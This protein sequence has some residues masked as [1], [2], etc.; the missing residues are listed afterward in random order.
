M[1][2]NIEKKTCFFRDVIQ[3]TL[4][5]VHIN[6]RCDILST[7]EFVYAVDH[8]TKL[9]SQ[10]DSGP[11]SVSTLQEIQNSLACVIKVVGTESFH[12]FLDVCLGKPVVVP[13][14]SKYDLITKVFH[15]TGYK[16]LD[17]LA[18]SA[19][20]AKKERKRT[21]PTGTGNTG[22]TGG[23]ETTDTPTCG[24]LFSTLECG[25]LSQISPCFFMQ[26]YGMKLHLEQGGKEII[27]LGFVDEEFSPHPYST[28][29]KEQG[30]KIGSPSEDVP[31]YQDYAK[32]LHLKDW[33][34]SSPHQLEYNYYTYITSVTNLYKRDLSTLIQ[35]FVL[36]DL[37]T[38]REM[39]VK[40]L[41]WPRTY[42]LA[43]LLY[44][45]LAN[46]NGSFDQVWMY[47][48]LPWELKK[49]VKEAK[50]V[51]EESVSFDIHQVPMEQQIALLRVEKSV[52]EK[53]MSKLKESKSRE[54]GG[55]ARQY[56]EGLLTIPFGVLR[57]EP[58]LCKKDELLQLLQPQP[59]PIVSAGKIYSRK[60]LEAMS[61][62]ELKDLGATSG[63]R[64]RQKKDAIIETLLTSPTYRAMKV[65]EEISQ[66]M[67]SF[68][69]TMDKAVYGHDPAKKQLEK[70]L[71][72]WVNGK[73]DGYCFGFEG[74]PGVGKTSLAKEGL[75][76][77]LV[78]EQGRPR[79]FAML[80]LGGDSNG[81]TL[82]GH[83]YTYTGSTW[84]AIVQ[85]LMDKKCMNP[86]I[87]IDEVDKISKTE[88][89]RE[90]IGILTHLLDS[91]QN[92]SFQDKYFAGIPLDLSKALFILSYNDPSVL[93]RVLLDRVHRIRFHPLSKKE[94]KVIVHRYLIP[95]ICDKMGFTDTTVDLQE[96]A[97]DA[98]IDIYTSE[99]GV[100]KCKELLF[101]IYGAINVTLLKYPRFLLPVVV[102]KENL[103]TVY[104]KDHPMYRPTYV[105]PLQRAGVCVGLWA[106]SEG[107]GGILP[108]QASWRSGGGDSSSSTSPSL[109]LTGTQGDTMK[110]SMHVALTLALTTTTPPPTTTPLG[111]NTIHIHC[112]DTSTPKD[113]P[114]AGAAITCAIRSL[115]TG[116]VIR[117]TLA[118]TGE[119]CLHGQVTEIGGLEQKF[120]GGIQAGIKEFLFPEE[121]RLDYERFL[122]SYPEYAADCGITFT[123]VQTIEEVFQ[124]VFLD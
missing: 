28:W 124:H 116:K 12:D 50:R 35:E 51:A 23:T 71:G 75:A 5:Y 112:P 63:G 70:I 74:P 18:A 93:D 109:F 100:R 115:M 21:K 102:T 105:N 14:E 22:N 117:P 66:I 82:H 29:L 16:V 107:K 31:R 9:S 83:N 86:I 119:V 2:D 17:T 94:K 65:R 110:E 92:D 30:S 7:N 3:K 88:H 56:L 123:S 39:L 68:R 76:G 38:K 95:E 72:Q 121:N 19:A 27:V 26:V 101:D 11:H 98:L 10:V 4:R 1:M 57:R 45:L 42:L 44:D 20:A 43:N 103:A 91:T 97:L 15:P 25:D 53:A 60:E 78:D 113:G 33:L 108:I 61:Y 37:Y 67:H 122:S 47:D 90:L 55:K 8:L 52:K 69:G 85:I 62:G 64:K 81:S 54:E 41:C 104:L 114:S 49:N 32:G 6:K 99:A 106:N 84:G 79:P 59:Q 34:V 58:I 77:C 48:S 120:L 24:Y 96:D 118:M 13:D 46:E 36:H 89:G 111:G 87:L 73:S 80:Q 40:L